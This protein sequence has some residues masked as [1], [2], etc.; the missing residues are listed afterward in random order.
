MY[1]KRLEL[2]GFKSFAPRTVLE[3]SPGITAIVGPNGSGKSNVADGIR[4]VLGE[5][6]MRQLR[7]KKSDD[8]IFVGGQGRAAT[9]MAEVGL[10]L[11]NSASWLPS[12]FAEV[13]A[14][15][16]AFRNGESEYLINGQRVRL[17]DVLLLLAQ[18]RIG[19]D[20]YTV[21]GQ[22]MVDQ[23][24]SARADERRALFEDAAGIRQFQTQRNDAEQKLNLTQGNLSRLRDILGEIEPRLAPLAEQ[25]R[26]AREF[27]STHADLGALLRLWYRRQWRE[28]YATA[29]RTDQAER[30]DAEHIQRIQATI[31]AQ[32]AHA[33]ELR[34]ER[35]AVL[36]AITGL[37]RERGEASGQLQTTE[38]D[39]AVARE[40]LASLDRQR[41][42]LVGEQ[43]Q[44]EEAIARA[45]AQLEALE[46]Q[47]A[48]AEEQVTEKATALE[49]L[50]RAQHIARQAQEREEARLRATQ[51]EVIQVQA[52]L[53]AA[54]TELGRLQRQLGERN[55]ALAARR[56]VA[57]QA[58]QKLD[59]AESQ[60]AERRHTFEA[61][62]TEVETLVTRR[63]QLTHE[64]GAGQTEI[65]RLRAA[66]ADTERERRSIADRLALLEE[67]RRTL[68]GL[69]AG[70]RALLQA[71]AEN[72][73]LMLGIVAQLVSTPSGTEAAIEAA[74]GPLLHAVLVSSRDDAQQA[75]QWL[76]ARGA[77]HAIFLWAESATD[78]ANVAEANAALPPADGVDYL[79][80]ARDLI[81]CPV[82]GHAAL[83]RVLGA[84]YIV[85]DTEVAQRHWATTPPPAPIV[86]LDGSVLH[87]HGWLRGGG[88]TAPS[89]D[90]HDASFLARERE[91]RQLPAEIERLTAQISESRTRLERASALQV[92]RK[93]HDERLRKDAQRAET[94][95]Q[96][97]ARIV[98][99]LQR[100]RE[101]ATG[102]L[103]LSDAMAEQLAAEVA[104]IEQE[105]AATTARAAEQERAQ[106]EATERVE[107][108]QMGME[109][110]LEQNRA[111]QEDLTRERTAIAVRRQEIKALTQRIEH[112]HG[113]VRE[114]RLQLGRRDERLQALALQREQLTE[115]TTTQT[116]SLTHLR[117]RAHHLG[118]QLRE[119]DTHQTTLERRITDIERGQNTE[120]QDLAR[121]EVE[122]RRSMVE[123]QRARDA[124]LA[125][126]GQIREELSGDTESDPR[127]LLAGD[128]GD[129]EEEE[130]RA[131]DLTPDALTKMRRQIDTLRSRLKHLGGYDPDAPQA[132]EEIKT[133]YDFLTSQVH[134]MEQA[135]ANL[136]AIITELDSTMRRQFEE[137]FRA[138]NE[139]FQRHFTTLFSGGAARLELTAPRRAQADDEEG[140][141]VAE[142]GLPRKVNLGG[143]EIYVQIP[144]KKVQDL[145]LLS[146]GERAMVSVALLFSL[147]ETNPPPFCL[148]DEVDAAL[149]EAN[150][151]RFCEIL[152]VLAEQTQFIVITHNRVTMTHANAIYGISMGADSVSRVLSMRLE[153]TALGRAAPP[154]AQPRA[155]VAAS[156]EPARG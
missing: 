65:E 133:R 62:R 132:Y 96:E 78:T 2:H 126:V 99:T 124:I 31:A 60:L 54:Q 152:R 147:L 21:I 33:Q 36:E 112:L 55:R 109:E 136:R 120:R 141:M 114:L 123:A 57:S 139:R 113:Q 117:E 5:Q 98:T 154:R 134:D 138:V 70:A 30:T 47:R 144:G 18:A 16:R 93:A 82:E 125:L 102:E 23:A 155:K 69:S 111:Q 73:P 61:A 121:L 128:D 63:E 97:V 90:G 14:A 49:A 140:D 40:R 95:A 39:L 32:E 7:G 116:D 42:E 156:T 88:G 146:G 104:G 48:E 58:R 46:D 41:T 89:G 118:E 26:R 119:R 52:R 130:A 8:V 13:T 137:T 35:A 59:V 87:P 3:F 38:R 76:R 122:Y 4:W 1:L 11:D 45:E 74:L 34:H 67:W 83:A 92:E 101:R 77:G 103:N 149:D 37:R 25:A 27:S 43:E 28:A 91:L 9:Q 53:G 145:S 80:Y 24:L 64:I 17:K 20:S 153:D 15:R 108:I 135:S 29:E 150:V 129:T 22:G 81:H 86:T 131:A 148:L 68:E 50:E 66:V 151:V 44:Q 84:T 107:D 115:L 127:Q 105:V 106:Q 56:D 71:P 85:R 110:L 142:P 75:A 94:H 79:G 6:S 12:E 19:H 10:V 72:R 143:V 51:R 100:E